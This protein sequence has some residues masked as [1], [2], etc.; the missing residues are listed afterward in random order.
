MLGIQRIEVL[1]DRIGVDR[2]ELLLTAEFTE[3]YV[4]KWTIWA[5]DETKKP[6][7]VISLTGEWRKIQSRLYNRILKRVLQPLPWSH[8]GVAGRHILTNATSHEGNEFL[9]VADISSFYPS[10]TCRQVNRLFLKRLK[11]A[12][13]VAR[14]L[15]RLCTYD[16]HLSLGLVTSP[17]LADQILRNVDLRI[18]EACACAGLTYTRYVDDIAI[19]GTFDLRRSGIPKL[20]ERILRSHGFRSEKSKQD[21]GRISEGMP[22]TKIRLSKGRPDVLKSYMTELERLLN[23]HASLSRGGDFVGPLLGSSQLAGKVYHV[24]WVNP[25]RRLYLRRKFRTIRWD[26]LWF[27]ANKRGLVSAEPKKTERGEERPSFERCFGNFVNPSDNDPGFIGVVD[28][29]E[30]AP[31]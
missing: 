23:D 18:A 12:P 15:T 20:V 29:N 27:E 31:F 2:G 30:E 4:R 1:A 16:H 8:G 25:G 5:P 13:D 22:V 28:L 24:C 10:I 17:I 3:E 21:F 14:I 19:S 11:C 26:R 9:F 6:R 7:N